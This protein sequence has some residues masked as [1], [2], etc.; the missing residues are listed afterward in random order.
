MQRIY[1]IL[2]FVFAMAGC[3]PHHT[4]Q[5]P[6]QA[7][8]VVLVTPQNQEQS[9]APTD[10]QND[11]ATASWGNQLC[12]VRGDEVDKNVFTIY[13]GKKVYFCC[14]GCIK[15]FEKNPENYLS[16]L[17]N[18]PVRTRPMPIEPSNGPTVP[19]EDSHAGHH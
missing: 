10:I 4:T 1:L 6:V 19:T 3:G 8:P 13:Q 14:S 9:A 12:P 18:N 2:M 17:L 16:A 5:Q 11:E 15:R 7:Q